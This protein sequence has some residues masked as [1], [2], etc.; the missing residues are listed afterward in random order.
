[1]ESQAVGT[2]LGLSGKAS[3]M[4]FKQRGEGMHRSG[5]AKMDKKGILEFIKFE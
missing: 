1:M 2:Q 4:V 3:E 5:R